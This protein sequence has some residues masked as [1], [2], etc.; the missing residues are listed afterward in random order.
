M[1]FLSSDFQAY[2][3]CRSVHMATLRQGFTYSQSS[4]AAIPDS[5][6]A[7]ESGATGDA[8]GDWMA[9]IAGV[10]AVSSGASYF[11]V[12]TSLLL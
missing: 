11:M 6:N 5:V 4:Y 3:T 7:G 1:V 10:N 8:L 2:R 12:F 9:L